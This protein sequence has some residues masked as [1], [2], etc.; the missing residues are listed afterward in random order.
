MAVPP[1]WAWKRGF[2]E[3]PGL[4]PFPSDGGGV[5]FGWAGCRDGL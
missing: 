5:G 1:A 3:D 4:L 2:Q